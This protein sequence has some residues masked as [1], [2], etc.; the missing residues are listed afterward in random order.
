MYLLDPFDSKYPDRL[1]EMTAGGLHNNGGVSEVYKA[2]C[3][4]Y[5][6]YELIRK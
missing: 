6:D 1:W 5:G 4:V 3:L 2:G